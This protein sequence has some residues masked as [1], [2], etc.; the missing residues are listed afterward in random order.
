MGVIRT[1]GVK[2]LSNLKI[3]KTG[4]LR[5]RKEKINQGAIIPLLAIDIGRNMSK[6]VLSVK[7]YV[8]SVSRLATLLKQCITPTI[9][10][11]RANNWGRIGLS[12][13]S[14][15]NPIEASSTTV[16]GQLI[17]HSCSLYTLI[18]YGAM[19]FFIVNGIV[20]R[21]GLEPTSVPQISIEMSD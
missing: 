13:C 4:R 2:G 11:N 15:S 7:K 8:I 21:L 1:L 20:E 19:H 18:D 17:F 9:Q 14:H 10:P 5:N 12:V 3:R 16:T 6:N